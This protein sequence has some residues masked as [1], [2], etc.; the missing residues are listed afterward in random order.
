MTAPQGAVKITL[1]P[2][3]VG[4]C[5]FE[6][7]DQFDPANTSLDD[8][9][10]ARLDTFHFIGDFTPEAY[11][12]TISTRPGGTIG[13]GWSLE[14]LY[15]TGALERPA[16]TSQPATVAFVPQDTDET[17]LGYSLRHR[18]MGNFTYVTVLSPSGERLAEKEFRSPR[19]AHEFIDTLPAAPVVVEDAEHYDVLMVELEALMDAKPD[20]PQALRLQAL[21]DAL[22]AFE[23]SRSTDSDGSAIS[24]EHPETDHDRDL[25]SRTG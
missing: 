9:Q 10:K 21:A 14:Y 23:A 25:R 7:G 3:K 6:P 19:K 13:R 20:T 17:Y 4:A 22:G 5:H 16:A 8:R 12:R 24:G 18:K 2:F 11:R 1:R 15:T